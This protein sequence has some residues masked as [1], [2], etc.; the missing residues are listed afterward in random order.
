M[1]PIKEVTLERTYDASP[2][3][4]CKLGLIRKK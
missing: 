3:K 4:V 2:D 1:E